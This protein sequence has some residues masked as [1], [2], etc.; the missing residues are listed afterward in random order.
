MGAAGFSPLL[1]VSRFSVDVF[2][3]DIFFLA[4]SG[5]DPPSVPSPPMEEVLLVLLRV[6]QTHIQVYYV[7]FD[8][9]PLYL[10][11]SLNL[12]LS[13]DENFPSWVRIF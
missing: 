6:G 9:G 12:S 7:R 1:S 2:L 5:P 11:V 4:L 8:S 10:D 13:N 3:E